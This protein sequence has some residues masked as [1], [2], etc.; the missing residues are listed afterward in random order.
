MSDY[1]T[2]LCRAFVAR[3]KEILSAHPQI[4]HNW[5]IDDDEDHCILD[6]PKVNEDGFDITVEVD[7]D[8]IVIRAH[9]YHQHV[10]EKDDNQKIESAFGLVRDLLSTSMRIK[11]YWVGGSPCRWEAQSSRNGEW[12]TEATTGLLFRNY[13]GKRLEKYYQ[14]NILPGRVG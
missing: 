5:S 9:G 3:A 4:Q 1:D 10:D 8:E 7:C 13:F 12:V 11:E 14:N 6:I 2:I